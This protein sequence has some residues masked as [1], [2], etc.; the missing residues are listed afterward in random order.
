MKILGKDYLLATLDFESFYGTKY[1]LT[2]MNTFTYVAD[3]RFSL[4]GVGLKLDDGQTKWYQDTD[5]A[6]A[7][8]ENA[9][10]KRPIA[11][12][13]HNGYF[14]GYI[15]HKCYDWHPDLYLDSMGMSRGLFPAQGA[16]L[17]KL[18]ERLWPDDLSM[19]KGKELVKFFNVSTE[20]LYANPAA[21]HAMIGYCCGNEKLKGDVDLTYQ[22]FVK[23]LPFY[24]DEELELIHLTLQMDCQ[25]IL[26]IDVPRVIACRDAA[27][28]E[29]DR[30]IKVSGLSET[31]LSSNAQFARW[32]EKHEVP[33][34]MK[35]SPTVKILDADGKPTDEA[36][37]IPALGKSDLG[38]QELRV[39]YPQHAAIWNGRVAAKSVGEITRAERFIAT[40]EQ[41]DG[42][43]PV[44][45]GYYAAHTGRYG[46]MEKLNLQNLGRGS[47][48][49]KSLIAPPGTM[50]YVADSSNIEARML[51]WEA[52][53]E[54][55]LQQF[56]DKQ[57]VYSNF[58]TQIYGKPI[59]K[60]DHPVERFIGKTCVLG[61]GYQVG[62]KKL[63]SSLAT[64]QEAVVLDDVEAQRIVSL[65]RTVNVLIKGYWAQAEQ[66]IIDMYMGNAREWGPLQIHRNCIVMP[67]GMALQYPGLRPATKED[68]KGNEYTDGWEYWN[69]KFWTNIYGGKL[70]L[71]QGTLVLT[72]NGW[73]AIEKIQPNTQVWDGLE[74]VS[75]AGNVYNG[76]KLTVELAGVSMTPDHEVLTDEGW[77]TASQVQGHNRADSRLPDSDGIRWQRWEEIPMAS[78]VHLRAEQDVCC[79][80]PS[81]V[82]KTRCDSIMRMQEKRDHI[83]A[84]D[85]TRD[86]TPPGLR[87]MA[88]HARSLPTT[89][90]PSLG[91]LRR[92]WHTGVQTMAGIIRSFLGGHGTHLPTGA[93]PG[94]NQQRA[95]LRA[96]QLP[97][98][99]L[100]NP[101]QQP[102]NVSTHQ[103]QDREAAIRGDWDR[104]VD[105]VVSDRAWLALGQAADPTGRNQPVYDL[106]NC[107]PRNRFVVRDANG[108]PLIVH[109]C[110]NITQALSRNILFTQ[111]LKINQLFLHHGGRVVMNV[112]DEII[113]VGPA[114]GGDKARCDALF[115]QMLDIMRESPP[116][117]P[118]L[119]L[120]GE[121]GWA[122]EYSK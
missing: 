57:D 52:G 24:P 80:G 101:S 64:S 74:W 51:A 54:T 119:P 5:D 120:D 46:G 21:I 104:G 41:C 63:Q 84:H 98:G 103:R 73:A 86:V 109:N 23:M 83:A 43:M 59:N 16:S 118:D 66:A 9:A 44:A 17:E 96:G 12:L 99:N 85:F 62:W 27:V 7:A 1:S 112:H 94:S 39:L 61:L 72:R 58:A 31:L 113:A 36:A 82:E 33:I 37:L 65:Y 18:C 38:F 48:L 30:L 19:R 34:P 56:R 71:A 35:P 91:Q 102:Q 28:L 42:L 10:G 32:M 22:A 45:L 115:G 40:A 2:S 116:W 47:E 121:G 117:C 90:A 3:E 79:H 97:L 4:H 55:L 78:P 87:R 20:A 100:R 50:I 93:H 122:P 95:A 25:P 49:R 89:L 106:I 69:G 107:G 111:M 53:H 15:L 108:K 13:C 67:N 81:E 29:R 114:Y 76:D 11:L 110:E 8:I 105:A 92:A 14:D 60:R 77:K 26:H 88:I 70:C 6:L 68:G 75:C